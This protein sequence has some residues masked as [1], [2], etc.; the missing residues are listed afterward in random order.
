MSDFLSF[1]NRYFITAEL[2]MEQPLHIGKGVSLEPVGTDLPIIKTRE[3]LP[4]IPGSSTKG[5]MRSELERIIRA[6]EA[7]KLD[8]NGKRL[9]ACDVF[10]APCVSEKEKETLETTSK[11]NGKVDEADFTQKL[12]ERTCTACRLFGSPWIA[13]RVYIKDMPLLE[14]KELFR[15]SEMRDGVAID[16]DTGTAR[17][18]AK[19]DYEVVPA[20]AR[21]TFEMVLENE[22]LWE[23]GLIGMILKLWTRGE[24]AIGGMTS[25]GLGWGKL[26]N[27]RIEKVD[28]TDLIEY[29]LNEK[30]QPVNLDDCVKEFQEKL[31]KGGEDA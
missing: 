12:W 16:R 21:F 22:E 15:V 3:D 13:S 11:K 19:F 20:K 28:R 23:V 5:V 26:E 2:V 18:H 25:R 17:K 14:R 4:F 9:T 1:H 27:I 24:I 7:Q 6:F 30:K 8:I 31:V 10:D 29:I